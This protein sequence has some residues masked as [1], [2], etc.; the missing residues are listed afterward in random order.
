VRILVTFISTVPETGGLFLLGSFLVL[1]GLVLRRVFAKVEKDE[2]APARVAE[3]PRLK[4][5]DQKAVFSQPVSG[6]L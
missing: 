4:A 6:Q 1:A 2:P 5:F 3:Q